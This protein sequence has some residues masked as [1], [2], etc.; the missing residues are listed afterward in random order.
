MTP[1]ETVVASMSQSH[2][3]GI[4]CLVLSFGSFM[5]INA[6]LLLR[7]MRAHRSPF[8]LS[9]RSRPGWHSRRTFHG[10]DHYLVAAPRARDSQKGAIEG[11][12]RLVT[13]EHGPRHTTGTGRPYQAANS[14]TKP[15]STD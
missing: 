5:S 15:E 2:S 4:V 11:V 13:S 8:R 1:S 12:H 7:R 9:D 14:S 3:M 6:L 10:A